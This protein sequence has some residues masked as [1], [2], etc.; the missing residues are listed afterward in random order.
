MGL[1]QAGL[2]KFSP[3]T[4][5]I[6]FFN[7]LQAMCYAHCFFRAFSSIPVIIYAFLPQLTLINSLPIFPKV[8]DPWFSVYAFLFLGSHGKDF[9]DHALAGSV[10]KKCWN[11]R[12]MSLILG[13]SSF[14]FSII[15]WF[16]TSIGLSTCELNVT[17]KVL[18]SELSKRYEK[19]VFE[20]GVESPLLLMISVTAMVNLFAFLVGI[21]K[22]LIDSE[23]FEALFV[24]VFIAG[25]GVV[26]S[27][28]VYEGMVLRSD[29]GKVPTTITLKSICVALVLCL[30]FSSAF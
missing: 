26:N 16:L 24:Q 4:Y 2:S 7:P 25:F 30:G 3:M 18:D 19:G 11:S 20:F 29:K 10:F 28:P 9:L 12:R 8:S 22:V 14:P 21:R 23:K 17:S 13:C 6:K 1:L 5:G 15:D 27:W